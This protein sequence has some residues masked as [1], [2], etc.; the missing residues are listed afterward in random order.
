MKI[1][2]IAFGWFWRFRFAGYTPEQDNRPSEVPVTANRNLIQLRFC[3]ASLA[4]LFRWVT[5]FLREST[6]VNS[7]CSLPQTR[8]ARLSPEEFPVFACGTS[9]HPTDL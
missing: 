8:L 9:L 2:R 5:S 6:S 4:K 7:V 3:N 1:F